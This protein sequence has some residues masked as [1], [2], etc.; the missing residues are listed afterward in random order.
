MTE[1]IIDY[2]MLRNNSSNY[3][4]RE[5]PKPKRTHFKALLC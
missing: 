2:L 1:Q 3:E 4:F 5:L